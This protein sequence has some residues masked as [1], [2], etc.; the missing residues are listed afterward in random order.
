M[1]EINVFCYST[2][3]PKHIEVQKAG[4]VANL[5]FPQTTAI[6]RSYSSVAAYVK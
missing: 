3:N 1:N 5:F 2:N 4:N 6:K